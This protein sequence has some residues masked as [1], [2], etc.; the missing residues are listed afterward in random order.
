MPHCT[1]NRRA[2]VTQQKEEESLKARDPP[3]TQADTAVARSSR[4]RVVQEHF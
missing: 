1:A 2:S 3:T 4:P